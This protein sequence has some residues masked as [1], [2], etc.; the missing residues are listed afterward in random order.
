MPPSGPSEKAAHG[1]LKPRLQIE[2]N[3]MFIVPTFEVLTPFVHE[4]RVL[5]RQRE[6][7]MAI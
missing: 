7:H 6:R 5:L 4:C 3:I 1:Q 2:V